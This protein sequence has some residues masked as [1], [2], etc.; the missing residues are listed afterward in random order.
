TKGTKL[1]TYVTSVSKRTTGGRRASTELD[2]AGPGAAAGAG[3]SAD[4]AGTLVAGEEPA[5]AS[6]SVRDPGEWAARGF[7]VESLSV[8]QA[9][10]DTRKPQQT[11]SGGASRT[12]TLV[13][14]RVRGL[15]EREARGARESGSLMLAPRKR[16]SRRSRRANGGVPPPAP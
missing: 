16:R 15:D 14:R 7:E 1:A 6:D 3:A 9:A 2:E 5:A 4:V 13:I 12:A 10:A 8:W 11:A